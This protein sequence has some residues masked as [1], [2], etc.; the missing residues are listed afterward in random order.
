M[1]RFRRFVFAAALVGLIALTAQARVAPPAPIVDRVAKANTV[2]IG[3][4]TSI[5]EKGV[6][7]D[8]AEYKVAIVKVKDAVKG[9]KDQTHLRV[10]FL[11]NARFPAHGVQKDLDVILFLNPVKGQPH[12]TTRMYYD[13]VNKTSPAWDKEVAATKACAA[14]AADPDKFLKDG[15]PEE[16]LL[17]AALLVLQY[18]DPS[19]TNGKQAPIAAAQS[20]AILTILADA[21]WTKQDSEGPLG[22]LNAQQLFFRLGATP[23]DG[24]TPPQNF[25][26][27][28]TEA[29]KWLKANADKFVVKKFLRDQE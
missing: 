17:A 9:A 26:T 28:Q 10:A 27:L 8:G 5:E 7:I 14:V 11:P 25:E 19:E 2:V 3:T 6:A 12:F 24:W 1:F 20:K 22:P 29:K 4:V 13:V 15:T 18:R 23:A 21:D 16:K